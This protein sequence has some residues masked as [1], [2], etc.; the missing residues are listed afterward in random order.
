MPEIT[1]AQAKAGNYQKRKMPW[2]GLTISI[3]NEAG[4]VRSGVDVD[5]HEWQTEMHYPY[6]YINKTTGADGDQLDVYVGPNENAEFVY[7]VRQNTAGDWAKFDEEKCMIGFDSEQEAESAYMAQYDDP[8]FFGGIVTIPTADFVGKAKATKNGHT[9][10]RADSAAPQTELE[11]IDAMIAGQLPSPQQSH[12][13]ILF[14]MRI[15]GTGFVERQDEAGNTIN[16]LRPA[17]VFASDEALQRYVAMP[18]ILEH[19]KAGVMQDGDF[20][21][22]IAGIVVKPYLVGSEVR[23][24]CRIYTREAIEAIASGIDSTSP[25]MITFSEPLDNSYG[26]MIETEKHILSVDHLAIVAD[27]RW[28]EK[29]GGKGIKINL[30]NDSKDSDMPDEIKPDLPKVDEV[31]EAVATKPEAVPEVKQDETPAEQKQEDDKL[32]SLQ[33]QLDDVQKV[34]AALTVPAVPAPI[35][36]AVPEVPDVPEVAAVPDSV[37]EQTAPAAPVAEIEPEKKDEPDMMPELSADEAQELSRLEEEARGFHTI[38][39]DSRTLSARQFGSVAKF[40]PALIEHF[41]KK[42]EGV[43]KNVR[44]MVDGATTIQSQKLVLSKIYSIMAD[45][46]SDVRAEKQAFWSQEEPG[47]GGV[48]TATLYNFVDVMAQ[49]HMEQK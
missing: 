37:M 16:V 36:D 33:K 3:E 40:L 28:D 4:S 11:I 20:Q 18:V 34:I 39:A 41:G 9:I 25:S 42:V 21:K 48:S 49:R 38:A 17:S 22:Q 35:A 44:A 1:E 31:P 29:S 19:P 32:A 45:S 46:K 30:F 2:N 10:I 13:G 27:G 5:G 24:I 7:V 14:D 23:G 26:K 6:G 12:S 8:R 15:T 43:D 47:R